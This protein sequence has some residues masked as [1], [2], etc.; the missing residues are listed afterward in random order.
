M[1]ETRHV[2]P[3]L[4]LQPLGT[5]ARG[6]VWRARDS[7]SGEER[8]L[9]LAALG[10]AA[11]CARL[12][13][14]ALVG[15][16]ASHPRLVQVFG[17]GEDPAAGVAWL[18]MECL[19][20][21]PAPLSLATFGQLL[22]ALACLHAGGIVHADIKPA[23]LLATSDGGLKLGDFGLARR[24]GSAA[25]AH[26]T[27]RYMSPEQMRGCAIGPASDVFSAGAILFELACGRKVFDGT[28]FDIVRQVLAASPSAP[29]PPGAPLE[30]LVRRALARDPA[31][32]FAD[33][34]EFLIQFRALCQL[35]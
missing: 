8:A 25:P 10:D 33:G 6:H 28:P 20:G 9:K 31:E 5:G 17:G 1:P 19:P 32:R 13:N 35:A 14:E 16:A 22:E 24:A 12:R 3:F 11:A 23:N 18:A 21:G 2:G 26:G 30:A 34:G 15:A 29:L 27:P 4:L 7:R